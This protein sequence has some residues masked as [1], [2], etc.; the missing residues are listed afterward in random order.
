MKKFLHCA[1]CHNFLVYINNDR[2]VCL[3]E[4]NHGYIYAVLKHVY[5]KH[6]EFEDN[7]VYCNKCKLRLGRFHYKSKYVLFKRDRL[8]QIIK[9]TDNKIRFIYAYGLPIADEH[10]YNRYYGY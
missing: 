3:D 7:F 4:E 2:L 6:L 1:Y 9:A 5:K 10:F 8:A